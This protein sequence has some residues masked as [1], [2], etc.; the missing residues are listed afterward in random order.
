MDCPDL[1]EKHQTIMQR[2]MAV[3]VMTYAGLALA[4]APDRG[5]G[6]KFNMPLA[7]SAPPNRESWAG[8]LSFLSRVFR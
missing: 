5:F 8:F 4:K 7:Y 3:A 1:K 2:W 6:A